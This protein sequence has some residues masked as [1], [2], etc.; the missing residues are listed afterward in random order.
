MPPDARDVMFCR[1]FRDGGLAQ[2]LHPAL[3]LEKSARPQYRKTIKAAAEK[4]TEVPRIQSQQHI[5]PRERAEK[6][7]TIFASSENNGT[8]Q[9]QNIVLDHQIPAQSH[10]VRARAIRKCGEILSDFVQHIRNCH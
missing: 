1:E 6:N 4:V 10:P 9:A 2:P 5:R 7:G 8:V 3:A